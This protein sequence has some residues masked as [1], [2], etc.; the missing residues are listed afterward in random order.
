MVYCLNQA[1][2][3]GDKRPPAS[4][5]A[6]LRRRAISSGEPRQ[7]LAYHASLPLAFAAGAYHRSLQFGG[8]VLRQKG[9]K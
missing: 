9:G 4:A 8:L 5:W 1:Q 2:A 3:G 7:Q 6:G